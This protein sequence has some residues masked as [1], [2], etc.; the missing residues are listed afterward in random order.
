MGGVYIIPVEVAEHVLA[1]VVG[2]AVLRTAILVLLPAVI[3]SKLSQLGL[4]LFLNVL[5]RVSS[6]LPVA[7]AQTAER[8]I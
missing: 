5:A 4:S 8:S 6:S 1:E 3:G 7:S 2:D